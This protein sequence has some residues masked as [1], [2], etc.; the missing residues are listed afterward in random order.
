MVSS[1][2][3]QLHS[4]SPVEDRSSHLAKGIWASHVEISPFVALE[5]GDE[6]LLKPLTRVCFLPWDD[7]D[8][9]HH[10]YHLPASGDHAGETQWT[11]EITSYFRAFAF[12][13]FPLPQPKSQPE[14]L[15]I[16]YLRCYLHWNFKEGSQCCFRAMCSQRFSVS[17]TNWF[18]RGF[19]VFFF[20]LN[21]APCWGNTL[22]W[23]CTYTTFARA[24]WL[25]LCSWG[26]RSPNTQKSSS[27]LSTPLSQPCTPGV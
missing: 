27:Q 2:T 25:E 6:R 15:E 21:V 14:S 8:I 3:G 9:T 1:L 10:M 16:R 23:R 12:L 4:H 24:W 19:L 7:Y 5:S 17:I 22:K 20:A 13:A 11:T 26:N 18:W